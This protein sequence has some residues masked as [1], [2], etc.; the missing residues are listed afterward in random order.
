M[1]MGIPT[2]ATAIG[3]NFRVIE[4]EV[5]GFLIRNEDEWIDRIMELVNDI[6]LRKRIGQQARKRVEEM[7]SLKANEFA[8]LKVLTDVLRD[9]RKQ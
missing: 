6:D 2:L 4:N 1:A 8:Y 7:F 3:A 5:S 9:E